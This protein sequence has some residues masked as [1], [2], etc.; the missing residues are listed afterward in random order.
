MLHRNP[1]YMLL[2]VYIPS[3]SIMLMTIVPLYLR[4][5]THFATTITLVL[6]AILCLYTL[7]QSS[8]S[9]IPKTAYLKL[10]DYWN[11]LSLTVTLANFFTL[12][13]WE[14]LD[15]RR[16]KMSKD[17]KNF[18]KIAIPLGT[19]FGV[20]TYWIAGAILYF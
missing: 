15:Q 10:I 12:I 1:S 8:I 20:V 18:M 17:I 6:T 13:I 5:D 7:L 4:Q 14:G 11:I 2:N 3:F 16:T 9:Q 19:L